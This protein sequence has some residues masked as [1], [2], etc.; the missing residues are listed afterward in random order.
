MIIQQCL[1]AIQSLVRTTLSPT[2]NVLVVGLAGVCL[3]WAGCGETSAPA[4]DATPPQ[5]WAQP[6]G[7]VFDQLPASIALASSKEAMIAYTLDGSRPTDASATYDAP[8][9]LPSSDVILRFVARDASGNTSPERVERYR[10]VPRAPQ[11]TLQTASPVILGP[12]QRTT[13]PWVCVRHC[14]R[15]RVT[16]GAGGEGQERLLAAG[17]AEEGQAMQTLIDAARLPAPAMRLWVQVTSNA[18]VLGAASLPLVIDRQPPQVRA[19]PAGGTYS[20]LSG[21]ELITDEAA[22]VYYTTDGSAPSRDAPVYTAPI[23]L[24]SDTTLRFLAMDPFANAAP[25]Q[26][27]VYRF[28]KP[29]PTVRLQQFPGFRL[30]VRTHL[31]VTWRS[32]QRGH[33]LLSANDQPLLRGRV[34]RNKPTRSRVPG[35]SLKTPHNRLRLSVT[36]EA[37][38]EGNTA[39]LLDTVFVETFAKTTAIDDESTTAAQDTDAG[40][41]DLPTGP[42]PGVYETRYTSRGV[43][44]QGHYAYLANTRGGV[45]VLDLAA[46]ET[47][48]L[49]GTFFMHGEP[50]ALAKY[51]RYV[52]LAADTSGVQIF[53]VSRPAPPVL[54]GHLR[55]PG[56]A[57]ALTIAG[58]RA[59]IGTHDRGLYMYD[60]TDPRRPTRVAHVPLTMPVMHIAATA[61][62]VYVAGFAEGVAIVDIAMPTAPTLLT[63]FKPDPY[64]ETVLGVAVHDDRL[65]V[66]ANSLTVFDVQNAAQPRRLA[67]LALRSAHGLAIAHR[68]VYVADQYEGIYIVDS[69]V[70][71]PR[72]L[73]AYDTPNRAVRLDLEGDLAFV[74]DVVGGLHICIS[75]MSHNPTGPRCYGVCQNWDK[76]SMSRSR[77]ASPISPIGGAVRGSSSS[78]CANLAKPASWGVIEMAH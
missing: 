66:A 2:P 21:I 13:I 18:G 22:T 63:T 23:R 70:P 62:H 11:L 1:T 51:G 59:Y 53:D 42:L 36:D 32:S 31:R 45:Q 17:M 6:A 73:G 28:R 37:G 16:A 56:R 75:S 71:Q 52:Y 67:R 76:S 4:V 26:T 74:A 9:T 77:T 25:I 78:M 61:T 40:R 65:Y 39:W 24:D 7:G 58:T 10:R 12:Q 55:L 35:W 30:D 29:A 72:L 44:S 38:N 33:Y 68:R 60:L 48:R 49:A 14:G 27:E 41:M 5:V 47:P 46:P 57:S 43:A 50:K 19:W 15:F 64:A 34:E 69:G 3:C 20:Q 54:V 8:L